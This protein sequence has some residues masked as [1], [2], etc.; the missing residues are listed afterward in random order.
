LA[1]ENDSDSFCRELRRQAARCAAKWPYERLNFELGGIGA[2]ALAILANAGFAHAAALPRSRAESMA[3]FSQGMLSIADGWPNALP[4][5]I[6]I[7]DR[8]VTQLDVA[9]ASVVWPALID[10]RRRA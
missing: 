9:T 3:T 1:R 6:G 7:L 8:V 10:L 2:S 4:A 5:V